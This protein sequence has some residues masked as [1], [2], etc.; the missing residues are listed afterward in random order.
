[1]NSTQLFSGIAAALFLQSVASAEPPAPSVE[2]VPGTLGTM[3]QGGVDTFLVVSERDPGIAYVDAHQG[4]QMRALDDAP[5]FRRVDLPG[6]DHTFTPVSSQ[7][8]VLELVT[9]HLSAYL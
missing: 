8:R 1:M 9:A 7:R 5:R 3:V 4:G 2:S 6:A